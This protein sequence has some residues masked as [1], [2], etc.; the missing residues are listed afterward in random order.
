M[1]FNYRT[2]KMGD[3][4]VR[5]RMPNQEGIYPV[6]IL[7]HGWTGDE[8]SMWVFEARLPNDAIIIAPRG[9]YPSPLGGYGWQKYSGDNWPVMEDF[10]LAINSILD[11]ILMPHSTQAD[12]SQLSLVGFSQGAALAYA[13]AI[14]HPKK[15]SAI[16][17]LSGFLPNDVESSL[18]HIDLQG[19]PIYIT[20]G[21]QDELVPVDKARY[22]VE[23][24]SLAGAEVSYCEENVGHKLSVACFNGMESF[25][26]TL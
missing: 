26:N 9:I 6:L 19:L 21:N 16:V 18:K 1:M 10:Q 14:E 15:V 24:L 8:N 22:A 17:T 5:Y 20:H 7:L 12:F 2:E 23:I 13:F 25:F 11:L 3:L 4:F